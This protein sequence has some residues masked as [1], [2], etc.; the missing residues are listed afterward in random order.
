MPEE[1][2]LQPVAPPERLASLDVLRG[3]AVLGILLVNIQDFSMV[4]AAYLNPTAFGDLT[5][6]NRW[7]WML[8][9]VLGDQKFMT[10]FSLL[11]GAGI[12]LVTSK[13]ESKGLPPAGLH[14]RRIFWLFVIGLMHAYLLWRGDILVAYA[15]CAVW[16]YLFRKKKPKT[17]LIAGAVFILVPTIL[18]LIFSWSVPYWPPEAVESNLQMWAPPAERIAQEVAVYRGGWL[19]QMG[20]RVP[21]AI[22]FQT[23]I[24]LIYIGWRV[25]GVMLIGMALFKWRVLSAERSGRF[26]RIMLAAGFGIG[27]PLIVTGVV[28]NF[29]AGWA[30]PY[31]MFIGWQ[32]N[33]L[34]SLGMAAGY[35]ALV[36]LLCRSARLPAL[37]ERLAAVGRMA[38]TNYLLQSLICTTLFY[39]HGFGLFGKVQR[40]QQVLITVAIWTTLLVV[41]P[42]WLRR[43]RFGPVEW[44]WRTLTY[45]KAQ[46]MRM[47]RTA[48]VIPDV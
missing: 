46:P 20:H 6:L 28:R 22:A 36:M 12:L 32:F 37:R 19:Q 21:S 47:P 10:I 1:K 33:Y 45:R 18:Y 14:Y 29:A 23:F 2:L 40:W 15:V 13:A 16:V 27:I 4:F 42:L 38:F 8:T 5:G 34:G 30:W 41:S 3:F 48:Q 44:L 9:H 39:G 17:L 35:I 7:A 11:F 24:F 26:Y 43:F 25:T 31:S